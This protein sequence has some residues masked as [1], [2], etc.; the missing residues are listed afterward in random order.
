MINASLL[1]ET[2]VGYKVKYSGG[3]L[4][5]VKAGQDLKLYVDGKNVRLRT[6]KGDFTYIPAAAITEVSY[7]QEVHHRI[8]TAVGLAVISLGIG[9][10]SLSVNRRSTTSALRGM[11]AGIKAGWRCKPTRT[12][13]AA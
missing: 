10:W 9:V 2:E 11:T 13:T 6:G 7:G 3:S 8:G 5:N 1:A 4:E 12:S